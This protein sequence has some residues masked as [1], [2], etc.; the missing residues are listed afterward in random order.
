MPLKENLESMRVL[1]RR[2]FWSGAYRHGVGSR[3]LGYENGRIARERAL[4]RKLSKARK[5][6]LKA[7]NELEDFRAREEA[8]KGDARGRTETPL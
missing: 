8:R 3:K 7:R 1:F 6:Y 5:R 4:V 2:D